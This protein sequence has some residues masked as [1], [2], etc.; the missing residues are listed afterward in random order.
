MANTAIVNVVKEQIA[1]GNF[2]GD[3][4]TELQAMEST[5]AG[6]CLIA[7]TDSLTDVYNGIKTAQQYLNASNC[8]YTFAVLSEA[9]DFSK[10]AELS[11]LAL[12]WDLSDFQ[13]YNSRLLS[14]CAQMKGLTNITYLMQNFLLRLFRLADYLKSLSYYNLGCDLP[15]LMGAAQAVTEPVLD[16]A[17]GDVLNLRW[18]QTRSGLTRAMGRY[19]IKDDYSF[20]TY[21][22]GSWYTIG[23]VPWNVE[24]G[25]YVEDGAGRLLLEGGFP[26]FNNGG[27]FEVH[28]G[29]TFTYDAEGKAIDYTSGV[30]DSSYPVTNFDN[31]LGVPDAFADNTPIEHTKPFT[32]ITEEQFDIANPTSLVNP[33]SPNYDEYYA[34]MYDAGVRPG[35]VLDEIVARFHVHVMSLVGQT[36]IENMQGSGVCEGAV[37]D[38]EETCLLNGGTWLSNI[39][40]VDP[41]KVL[42]STNVF[43]LYASSREQMFALTAS[44]GDMVERLD[45]G[46][47]FVRTTEEYL[48]TDTEPDMKVEGEG[49][50]VA[51]YHYEYTESTRNVVGLGDSLES[52]ASDG[53]ISRQEIPALIKKLDEITA[54]YNSYNDAGGKKEVI[55]TDF[56]NA[57]ADCLAAGGDPNKVSLV[58]DIKIN[59]NS[60]NYTLPTAYTVVSTTL[61]H[62]TLGWIINEYKTGGLFPK[63]DTDI[64]LGNPANYDSS[65][66]IELEAN[67][68]DSFIYKINQF[69]K[70]IELV[71]KYFNDLTAAIA[72]L[73]KIKTE[74]QLEIEGLDRVVYG[75]NKTQPYPGEGTVRTGAPNFFYGFNEPHIERV[76][77]I[78]ADSRLDAFHGDVWYD[79]VN[80]Q[81][82]MYLRVESDPVT[83]PKTYT[84]KWYVDGTT[85]TV[86]NGGASETINIVESN[87]DNLDGVVRSHV[88]ATDP[89]VGW[90]IHEKWLNQG[91]VWVDTSIPAQKTWYYNGTSGQWL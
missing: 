65:Q 77:H 43:K 17:G 2:I 29:G 14:M 22:D 21:A 76:L 37:G 75:H 68:V 42:A 88:Q 45:L 31:T 38:D 74:A 59:Y 62:G 16:V 49:N 83:D 15:K 54:L 46:Q 50:P 63:V 25:F 10:G 64:N 36:L 7:T 72:E 90:N 19:Q 1:S 32:S 53:E 26:V 71:E 5:L 73:S 69:Y 66:L 48:D 61:T 82:K 80:K 78:Q 30:F 70:E 23:G 33:S 4:L 91:D 67:N 89:S 24:P 47:T 8:A 44:A 87:F 27:S 13:D 86:T 41:T 11:A 40:F 52:L 28:S 12:S 35:Q 18:E 56:D 57:V 55:E 60:G 58:Q 3:K 34:V 85:V 84:Y 9:I 51:P 81:A 6:G 20:K 39:E 79:A